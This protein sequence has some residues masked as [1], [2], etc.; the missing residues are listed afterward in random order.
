[1]RLTDGFRLSDDQVDY[2][3]QEFKDLNEKLK[4]GKLEGTFRM[5]ARQEALLALYDLHKIEVK[6]IKELGDNVALTNFVQSKEI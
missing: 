2:L 4:E 3:R 5:V 1:M 6:R